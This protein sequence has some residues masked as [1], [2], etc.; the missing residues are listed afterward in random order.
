MQIQLTAQGKEY[1]RYSERLIDEMTYTES[2]LKGELTTV[3]G[4]LKLSVP[5]TM[6]T[7]LLANQ[8]VN[9]CLFTQSL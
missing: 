3:K 4:E 8:L 5:S 2:R 7:K 1:L 6:A 9:L